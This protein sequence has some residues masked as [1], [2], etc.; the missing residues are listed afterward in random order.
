MK[1]IRL[2]ASPILMYVLAGVYALVLAIATFVENSSGP[3]VAREYFYY[4][5]WFIL[6]QLLQAVNL[7]AMFLQGG[8]FKRISKG[9]LIFHGALVFICTLVHKSY[10]APVSDRRSS[11]LLCGAGDAV[12]GFGGFGSVYDG[13]L[14]GPYGENAQQV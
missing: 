8:Y 4:A 1:L 2:I 14:Q 10:G 7:L 9:S 5:P 3:A 13:G 12:G 6:L 11:G